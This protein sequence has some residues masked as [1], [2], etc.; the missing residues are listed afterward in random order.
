[1]PTANALPILPISGP[2]VSVAPRAGLDPATNLSL[3]FEKVTG[4][5]HPILRFR[6]WYARDVMTTYDDVCVLKLDVYCA[7]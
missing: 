1:M 2:L 7:M 6:G 5:H 4:H 3:R